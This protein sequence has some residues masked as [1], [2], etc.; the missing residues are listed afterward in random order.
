M[1]R[2]FLATFAPP[3]TKPGAPFAPLPPS[4]PLPTD[5]ASPPLPAAPP[6]PA[7]A[8]LPAEPAPASFG[9]NV[10]PVGSDQERYQL[11]VITGR[12][13]TAATQLLLGPVARGMTV[14]LAQPGTTGRP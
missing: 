1:E 2:V 13:A 10:G 14:S 12:R 7:E 8:P 4:P 3:G 9:G 11:S 6:L 5:P